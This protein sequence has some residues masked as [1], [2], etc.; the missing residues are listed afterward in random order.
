MRPEFAGQL[1]DDGVAP[2]EQAEAQH[3]VGGGEH[4]CVQRPQAHVDQ[5]RGME[6][7]AP[8][9]DRAEETP[10]A[11]ASAARL[12]AASVVERGERQ[13]AAERRP[14]IGRGGPEILQD[15]AL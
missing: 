3:A 12:T 5:R 11:D 1:G 6:E 10:H 13:G 7:N 15:R 2:E 4:D 14:A 9:E 8:G